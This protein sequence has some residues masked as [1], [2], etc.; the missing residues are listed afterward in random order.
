MSLAELFYAKHSRR[1]KLI[2]PKRRSALRK[3]QKLFFEPLEPRLLLSVNLWS[4]VI[5][6]GTVWHAGDV[7][8]ITAD[9]SVPQGSTLTVQPGAIVQFDPFAGIDLTVEGTLDARGTAASPILFTSI[10][11]DTG[12]DGVLGTAD[13]VDTGG[14]GASNG[15]NG[16][17]NSIQFAPTSTGNILDHVDVRFGGAGSFAQV[18][19]DGGQLALTNSTIRNST[20]AGLRIANSNPTVT[21]NTFQDSFGAAVAMDLASNPDIRGVTLVNNGVNGLVLDAGTLSGARRWD[22]PD[23]VYRLSGNVKVAAGAT[24]TIAP[25]ER[26]RTR[27]NSSH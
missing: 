22:D 14:N 21:G 18:V 23:I 12:F 16:D 11:D 19:G 1:A 17:W 26:E 5:P 27:L 25:G 8:R 7:Q 3:R 20:T 9:V 13:D 4:G 15:G 6:A 10:R 24:L 2:P